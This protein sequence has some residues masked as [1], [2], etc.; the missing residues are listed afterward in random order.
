MVE[1]MEDLIVIKFKLLKSEYEYVAAQATINGTSFTYE[2]RKAIELQKKLR[3]HIV[4][5]GDILLDYPNGLRQEVV[6]R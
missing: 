2:I 5:G 1:D 6:V 4:D 3:N